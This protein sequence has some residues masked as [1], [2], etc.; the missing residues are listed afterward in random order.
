[1]DTQNS[2]TKQYAVYIAGGGIVALVVLAL[3]YWLTEPV[4]ARLNPTYEPKAVVL[5][6][7]ESREGSATATSRRENAV[8]Q[9]GHPN[10]KCSPRSSRVLWYGDPY[11]GTVPM[12]PMPALDSDDPTRADFTHA[13]IKPREPQLMYYNMDPDKHCAAC[14][15]GQTVPFPKNN[16]P[17]ELGMHQDVVENALNLQHGRGTMWCLDCHDATNRNTLRNRMGQQVGFSEPQKLCGSCHG[18]IYANWRNGIHG[19]RIGS[20]KTDGKKRWWLCTECHNPHTV[21]QHRFNPIRPEA[22]PE[23]PRGMKNAHFEHTEAVATGQA[24]AASLN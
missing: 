4:D 18:Q 1:M 3:T 12:A 16:Q 8:P 21:Q 14:H 2:G 10:V 22:A 23:L 13:V 20:W 9:Y 15:D 17:R 19:K 5:D 6:C 11:D 24:P 7:H